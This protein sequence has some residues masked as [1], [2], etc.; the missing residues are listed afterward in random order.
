MQ[1]QSRFESL[2]NDTLTI[3][4]SSRRLV[5]AARVV[6]VLLAMVCGVTSVW[7]QGAD[8]PA[9]VV[10]SAGEIDGSGKAHIDRYIAPFLEKMRSGK[11]DEIKDAR[12]K[13]IE[14]VS[15]G[16]AP[17][18]SFRLAYTRA[19]VNELEK[20]LD[21][22][23][24]KPE[25]KSLVEMGQV[26]ALVICGELAAGEV[27]KVL[28]KGRA[29][30]LASV[31]YQSAMAAERVLAIVIKEPASPLAAQ[32]VI[33]L[34][35]AQGDVLK[36]EKDL[37]IID[38]A[39]STLVLGVTQAAYRSESLKQLDEGLLVI[40]KMYEGKVVPDELIQALAR[41]AS[42]LR[43]AMLSV[44]VAAMPQADKAA[45]GGI[46]ATIVWLARTSIN[47]KQVPFAPA[48]ASVRE[49]WGQAVGASESFGSLLTKNNNAINLSQKVRIGNGAG[50]ASFLG[51]GNDFIK[52]MGS[53]MG[54]PTGRYPDIK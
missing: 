6:A 18:V 49:R 32:E 1:T 5:D 10:Q 17:S 39:L 19:L 53:Q 36:N 54:V 52:S 4:R 16:R 35:K 3:S 20:F 38:K 28:A 45:A 33:A 34:L 40:A 50:D 47:A 41:T 44:N 8:I 31:R 23:P 42:D 11:P 37:L 9:S 12:N 30:D 15:P 14:M 46:P 26:N 24:A 27:P 21:A 25:D 51:A 22:K 48:G 7:A 2:Q 43:G 29:S 13:L